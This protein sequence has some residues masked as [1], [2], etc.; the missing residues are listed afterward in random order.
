M[1]VTLEPLQLV[2]TW[3]PGGDLREYV[4]KNPDTN[5]ISL[6]SRALSG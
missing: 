5:R 3:M 2:S 1:G 6:V 4:G